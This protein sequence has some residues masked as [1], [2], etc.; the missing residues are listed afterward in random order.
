MS[1]IVLGNIHYFYVIYHGKIYSQYE[2]IYTYVSACT[3]FQRGHLI[4]FFL[5]S[6]LYYPVCITVPCYMH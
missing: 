6:I 2:Y 5:L 4:F 3:T 1:T